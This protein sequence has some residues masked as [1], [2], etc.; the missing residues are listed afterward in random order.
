MHSGSVLQTEED[1][2]GRAVVLAARITGRARGGEIL[3]SQACRDYTEHVGDWR[4]GRPA[5]LSLKGL[6]SIERVFP[7]DWAAF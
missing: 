1:Y 4:Y 2:L 5:E 3:V 7:L 6:A